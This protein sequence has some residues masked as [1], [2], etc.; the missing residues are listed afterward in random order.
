MKLVFHLI[1]DSTYLHGID[2]YFFLF[3]SR[4]DGLTLKNKWIS[5][6]QVASDES[7]SHI[8]QTKVHTLQ[9]YNLMNKVFVR[10]GLRVKF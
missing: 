2:A 4:R 5:I 7:N 3:I 10:I 6:E 9:D 8:K 1:L